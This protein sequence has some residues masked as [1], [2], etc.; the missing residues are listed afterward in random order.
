MM[1]KWGEAYRGPGAAD[2]KKTRAERESEL[3]RM[4]RTERGRDVIEA[5]FL[6]YSGVTRGL[7]PPAG[8]RVGD[9]ILDH[10]YPNG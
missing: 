9:V 2:P 5:L 10:E 8:R 1:L 7:C 6:I 3:R 4:A